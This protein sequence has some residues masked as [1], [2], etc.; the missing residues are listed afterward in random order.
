MKR[1]ALLLA[2]L[3]CLGATR[4]EKVIQEDRELAEEHGWIHRDVDRG[5][6]QATKTGK[7]LLVVLRCP[8]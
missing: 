3:S 7:P 4:I 8:T 2:A 1:L 5:F 6:A